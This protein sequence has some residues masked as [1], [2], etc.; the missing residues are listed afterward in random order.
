MFH[1][2]RT[3]LSRV[4]RVRPVVLA[5]P[6]PPYVRSV[7]RLAPRTRPVVV[8]AERRLRRTVMRLALDGLVVATA[9]GTV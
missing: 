1:R 6:Q 7:L 4:L 9:R 3:R 5:Q 8:D 2:I